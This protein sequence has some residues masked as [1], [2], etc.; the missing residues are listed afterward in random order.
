MALDFG[1]LSNDKGTSKS[2]KKKT[3]TPPVNTRK[4]TEIKPKFF[5][6]EEI[7]A[8]FVVYKDRINE[9]V[10]TA[11]NH[12][13][14][15]DSS[16]AKAVVMAGEARKLS[17]KLDDVRLGATRPY[18]E[19]AGQVNSLAKS[20]IGPLEEIVKILKKKNSD[21]SYKKLIEERKRKEEER[22]AQEKLQA[23]LDKEAEEAGVDPVQLPAQPAT[24]ATQEKTMT[25]TDTGASASVQLVWK[26]TIVESEKVPREYCEPVQKL[27]DEAVK[28]G[29]REIPGVT[30]EEVPESRL[31]V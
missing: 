30:I 31:R 22:K 20:F 3:E 5:N 25:R 11:R 10:E 14:V 8:A 28:Q 13:V 23:E 29:V 2:R 24:G 27:I 4:G 9:M 6:I 15:D 17:K 19:F 16:D 18:R 12:E 7:K 26:G 21:Y 1:A